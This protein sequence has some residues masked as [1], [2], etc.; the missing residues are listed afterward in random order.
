MRFGGKVNLQKSR[1]RELETY[2]IVILV[3][4]TS[5]ALSDTHYTMLTS[6]QSTLKMIYN[7]N[8]T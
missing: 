1:Y 7:Y 3:F 8:S 6:R 4:K 5:D 2:F